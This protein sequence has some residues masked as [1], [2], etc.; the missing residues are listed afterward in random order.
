MTNGT[1]EGKQTQKGMEK[2]RSELTLEQTPAPA[3]SL[4]NT[5]RYLTAI[6]KLIK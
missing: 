5:T 1:P 4:K 2:Y 3:S 6:H